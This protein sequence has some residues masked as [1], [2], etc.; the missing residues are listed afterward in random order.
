MINPN[1]SV[2]VLA[3]QLLEEARGLFDRVLISPDRE[4]VMAMVDR[5]AWK[6]DELERDRAAA[7]EADPDS[8]LGPDLAT[9]IE[10]LTMGSALLAAA[11]VF[12]PIEM[13]SRRSIATPAVPAKPS[14]PDDG[15]IYIDGEAV[16]YAPL[17]DS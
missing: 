5:L 2:E 17:F 14:D 4:A 3:E 13:L 9:T 12:H 7:L 6:V 15:N 16:A 11:D 8:M 1:A 10:Q